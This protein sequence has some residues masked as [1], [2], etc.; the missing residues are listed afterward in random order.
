MKPIDKFIFT[1][2][3]MDGPEVM[4]V[5]RILK[6]KLYDNE[7]DKVRDTEDII[8]DM[9]KNFMAHSR[10]ERR[11]LLK[12]MDQAAKAPKIDNA[13]TAAKSEQAGSDKNESN[14]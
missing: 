11:R 1:L 3:Q 13:Q 10:P 7:K 6:V 5:A 4:G 9:M 2:R 12:I 8:L 14:S